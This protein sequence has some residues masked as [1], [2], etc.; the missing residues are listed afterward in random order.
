[1][2]DLVAQENNFMTVK[3]LKETMKIGINTAYALCQRDDFPAVKIGATYRIPVAEFK[4]WYE[5]QAY[6]E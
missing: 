3:D 5:K 6:K 1:M 4:K 2:A